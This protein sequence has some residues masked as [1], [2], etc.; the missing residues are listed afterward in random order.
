MLGQEIVE[1][2]FS[3]QTGHARVNKERGFIARVERT[4]RAVD[5][6]PSDDARRPE[7][8]T[9]SRFDALFYTYK[10]LTG[11]NGSAVQSRVLSVL[12]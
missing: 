3:P 12:S 11:N 1:K 8:D 2:K 10:H 4:L 9:F 7:E 5:D 6:N